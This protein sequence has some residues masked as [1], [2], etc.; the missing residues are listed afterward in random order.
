ME[1]TNMDFVRDAILN[2]IAEDG[3]INDMWLVAEHA[4]TPERLSEAANIW[5]QTQPASCVVA[6]IAVS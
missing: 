2:I 4:E 1:P 6:G 3:D 5:A